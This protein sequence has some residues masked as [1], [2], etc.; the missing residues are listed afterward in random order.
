MKSKILLIVTS[1]ALAVSLR[2]AVAADS[3]SSKHLFILSGQSN[4]R[5]PMIKTFTDTMKKALGEDQVI[6]V[7]L[8][9]PSAPIRCW[10]R[11]WPAPEGVKPLANGAELYDKLMMNV[12]KSIKGQQIKSTTFVWMQGEADAESGWASRYEESF[13][14]VLDQ[15]KKDLGIQEI[16]FVLGRINDY[17]LPGRRIVDG[18][19]MRALQ[20]KMAESSPRGAWINTDDLNTGVNPWGTYEFDGGHFPNPGYRVMGKRFA[21]QA[22]KL[23]APDVKF[24]ESLFAEAFIDDARQVKT[25][26]ALG[27][28]ITGTAPDA[29]HSGGKADVAALVDGKLGTS[30]PNDAAWLAYPPTATNIAFVMDLGQP[31]DVSSVAINLLVN[32]AAT[33]HFPTKI[34]VSISADGNDYKHLLSGRSNAV[35]FDKHARQLNLAK[36][37]TP[38]ARLIFIDKPAPAVRYVKVEIVPDTANKAW[39]YLDEIMVNPVVN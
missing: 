27:K 37:F 13:F 4:M 17:W 28:A 24:Y 32:H 2:S 33:A 8:G 15:L 12:Q 20:V 7:S 6:V 26:L 31:T 21:R 14:G 9:Q 22:C 11:N 36:D 23:V 5:D 39:L 18:D 30:D 29:A 35:F 38:G 19:K 16:N 1:F 25:N 10:Y 34:D 3:K